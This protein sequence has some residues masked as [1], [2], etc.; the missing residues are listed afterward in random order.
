MNLTANWNW[1]TSMYTNSKQYKLTCRSEHLS[2]LQTKTKRT[3][4][5]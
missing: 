1:K 5:T 4:V 3:P 2:K